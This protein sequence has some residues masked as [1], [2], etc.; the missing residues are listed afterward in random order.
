MEEQAFQS[1]A[2]NSE[3]YRDLLYNIPQHII[4]SK[5]FSFADF[6][7][8]WKCLPHYVQTR[9]P[10][11]VFESAE[12]G[13]NL[14][15]FYSKAKS[16]IEDNEDGEGDLSDYHYCLILIHTT[17]ES[18]FGAFIS[19]FPSFDPRNPFV[20]T[21]DSFVFSLAPFGFK[22]Y[23][24]KSETN[25]YYMECNPNYIS[26]GSGFDGPAIRVDGNLGKGS[27]NR[28]E[29]FESPV[30]AGN[31]EK[32]VDDAFEVYNVELFIL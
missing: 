21:S 4:K 31:G 26:I 11:K 18:K 32:H 13:F 14:Q 12:D 6:T 3:H 28:C 1:V 22:M 25:K 24:A 5:I 20:G 15:T 9:K 30:L 10:V 17:S 27:T 29:T 19:A 23:Q 8:I 16:F 2:R 7:D